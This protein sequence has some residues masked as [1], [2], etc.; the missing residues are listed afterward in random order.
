MNQ[1][2]D[3]CKDIE[4]TINQSVQNT[5]NAL[6]RD[7]QH[8]ISILEKKI[9]ADAVVRRSNTSNRIKR[10]TSH[11]VLLP[12]LLRTSL[13]KIFQFSVNLHLDDVMIL[14]IH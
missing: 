2:E 6:E 8:I 13:L 9:S 14:L 5:M 12:F 1:I 11:A 3:V 7:S 4:K 10:E